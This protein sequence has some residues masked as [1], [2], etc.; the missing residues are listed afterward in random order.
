MKGYLDFEDVLKIGAVFIVGMWFLLIFNPVR[1]DYTSCQDAE[2][3]ITGQSEI[4]RLE[5][6]IIDCN[7][8]KR[9]ATERCNEKLNSIIALVF[10]TALFLG[11][12]L[13]IP[14]WALIQWIGKH[15][16]KRKEKKNGNKGNK[17]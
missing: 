3:T 14:L 12:V 13:A 9:Y 5:K 8:Q 7:E 15:E 16:I 17:K 6:K 11:L 2:I 4:E 10:V 1:I